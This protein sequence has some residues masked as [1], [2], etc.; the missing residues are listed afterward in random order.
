MLKTVRDTPPRHAAYTPWLAGAFA[1]EPHRRQS[2]DR[3]QL[4]HIREYAHSLGTVLRNA[5]VACCAPSD[6][7]GSNREIRPAARFF[8]SPHILSTG[9]RLHAQTLCISGRAAC[10]DA[11]PRGLSITSPSHRGHPHPRCKFLRKSSKRLLRFCP[12]PHRSRPPT[13]RAISSVGRAPRLHRGCRRFE[14]VIAHHFLPRVSTS[15]LRIRGFLAS[16]GR[17]MTSRFPVRQLCFLF[18][19]SL[20][21]SPI[22][23]THRIFLI[24][25]RQSW[26]PC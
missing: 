12:V 4:I 17:A 19:C 21:Y 26:L 6:L 5:A 10:S 1:V 9:A 3:L 8:L 20:H 18:D 24:R 11:L 16:R 7:R 15:A 14:S 13:R 22:C 23:P 2:E 25:R